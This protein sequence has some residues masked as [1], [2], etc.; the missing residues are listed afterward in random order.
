[1]R[2]LVK[3]IMFYVFGKLD[4]TIKLAENIEHY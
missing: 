1:M 3:L 2:L 4:S